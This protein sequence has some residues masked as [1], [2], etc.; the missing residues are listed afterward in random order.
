[1]RQYSIPFYWEII[2]HCIDRPDP[3]HSSVGGHL[4][5]SHLLA[6]RSNTARNVLLFSDAE[7]YSFVKY[8]PKYFFDV[9]VDGIFL[10]SSL[11]YSLLVYRD[12]IDVCVFILYPVILLNLFNSSLVDFLSFS[13]CKNTSSADR[14]NLTSSFPIWVSFISFSSLITLAGNSSTVSWKWQAQTS[15]F[16]SWSERERRE[17]RPYVFHH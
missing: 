3:I 11:Y 8:I 9:T 10:I 5:C 4:D 12:A 2:P 17:R 16:R 6:V 13:I 1:M 14:D 7:L 15:L